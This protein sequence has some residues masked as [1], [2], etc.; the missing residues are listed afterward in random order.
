MNWGSPTYILI[1][2]LAYLL[3]TAW[4]VW[5]YTTGVETEEDYYVAGRS[6]GPFANTMTIIATIMS[7]GIYLGTV[8]FFYQ[9]QLP[10]LRFRLRWHGVRTLVRRQAALAGGE[11]VRLQH[12]A[13]PLRRSVPERVPTASRAVERKHPGRGMVRAL[14]AEGG[15]VDAAHGSSKGDVR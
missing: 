5:K 3:I 6:V 12:P 14:L 8:G 15:I 1:W 4:I 7:G 13:G 2:L 9:H 11:E 10:G